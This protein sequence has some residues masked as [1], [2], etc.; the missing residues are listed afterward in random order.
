MLKTV[1]PRRG[2][3]PPLS[4]READFKFVD[5]RIVH[6]FVLLTCIM[7]TASVPNTVDKNPAMPLLK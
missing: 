6:F 2:L 3:E 7:C 1:V 5:G 4:Y